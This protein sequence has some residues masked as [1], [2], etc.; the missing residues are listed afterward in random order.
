M[1]E[2]RRARDRRSHLIFGSCCGVMRYDAAWDP[3]M[4]G[5][6]SRSQQVALR[7]PSITKQHRSLQ[8]FQTSPQTTNWSP[9]TMY[10]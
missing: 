7:Q 8:I 5:K 3:R 6:R 4:F 10:A 2:G 9:S 1:L